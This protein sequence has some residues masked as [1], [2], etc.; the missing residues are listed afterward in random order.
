MIT[1][2]HQTEPFQAF[3]CLIQLCYAIKFQQRLELR[4]R[5]AAGDLSSREVD[6]FGLSYSGD[7]WFLAAQCLLRSDFRTFRVDRIEDLQHVDEP[8]DSRSP[9][10]YSA[11]QNG[12]R[13]FSPDGTGLRASVRLSGTVAR[14]N[15]PL[16]PS[17][18]YEYLDDGVVL[19]HLRVSSLSTLAELVAT[20]G[21]EADLVYPMAGVEAMRR[22]R[23]R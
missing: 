16:F 17:A 12:S 11:R 3:D 14:N 10:G 2:R 22:L 9:P 13:S 1:A 7:R 5:D 8:V 15:R 23:G 6:P 21:H 18:M 19:C 20:L 4:Y